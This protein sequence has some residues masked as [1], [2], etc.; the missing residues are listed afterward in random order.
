VFG[1]KN[2]FSGAVAF[3]LLTAV[4]VAFDRS[5]RFWLRVTAAC[6][7]VFSNLAGAIVV[8]AFAFA[9]I[10]FVL[11]DPASAPHPS[12]DSCFCDPCIN[13]LHHSRLVLS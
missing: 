6:V 11:G 12:C 1:S 7:A 3:L 13:G 8:Y 2:S 10:Q 5:Q 9:I 4:V